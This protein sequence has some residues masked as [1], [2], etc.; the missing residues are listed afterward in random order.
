MNR[1]VVS[2][3]T[4]GLSVG[5]TTAA[6]AADVSPA[7]P[8]A[9]APVPPFTWTGAYFGVNGG[10]GWQ[11]D[12][13]AIDLTNPTA[14]TNGLSDKGG[15]VGVELGYNYQIGMFV[16]GVETDAEA[17]NIKN[18]LTANVGS[19]VTGGNLL[20]SSNWGDFLTARGRVGVAFDHLLLYGTGG[21][22]LASVNNTLT[23][24]FT[25]GSQSALQNG[26]TQLGYVVGAG[27]EYA[28]D[29][30]WTVKAEYQ[31]INV[32]SYT[33]SGPQINAAG[34]PTGLTTS[35][36]SINN[37]IQTVRFGV[38]YRFYQ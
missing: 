2:L 16:L 33:L 34:N 5:L 23:V 8:Y 17:S 37:D 11:S 14:T 15:L 4:A 1:F 19:G 13:N 21:A 28:I 35:S 10:Y 31:Y 20:A 27:L 9:K 30:T 38:N 3:A 26:A 7:P 6:F 36:N 29:R 24:N 12:S 22:A 25:N 32:G 18:S